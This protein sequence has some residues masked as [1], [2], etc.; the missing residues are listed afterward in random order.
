MQ[1]RSDRRRLLK[2]RKKEASMKKKAEAKVE[3]IASLEKTVKCM[4]CG[5]DISQMTEHHLKEECNE[6]AK[7]MTLADYKESYPEAP[8]VS[9]FTQ[10]T[11]TEARERAAVRGVRL[12]KKLMPK[13]PQAKKLQVGQDEIAKRIEQLEGGMGQLHLMMSTLMELLDRKGVFLY[14]EY[15]EVREGVL[16]SIRQAEQPPPPSPTKPKSSAK[17]V[18]K[19]T[20][21]AEEV[22]TPPEQKK[23][24]ED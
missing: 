19:A 6:D 21:Q 15:N 20:D 14:S 17:I 24:E 8:I 7:G 9:P 23:K 3:H 16:A 22:T 18:D 1:T 13:V 10:A 12:Q 11:Q 5:K 4:I 2:A